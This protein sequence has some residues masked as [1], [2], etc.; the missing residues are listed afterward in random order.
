[1]SFFVSFSFCLL[2]LPLASLAQ[3]K[4]KETKQ[5]TKWPP[6]ANRIVEH[7]SRTC[8]AEEEEEEAALLPLSVATSAPP[9]PPF[10][11]V[12]SRTRTDATTAA[13]AYSSDAS[14]PPAETPASLSKSGATTATGNCR[15][16]K[17]KAQ[18][19]G[20]NGS[21]PLAIEWSEAPPVTQ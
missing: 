19:A 8:H 14:A 15:I 4:E 7:A 1:M 18:A 2:L 6:K 20:E 9:T 11:F 10:P 13:L 16:P 5:L 3:R 12:A 21:A 17:R